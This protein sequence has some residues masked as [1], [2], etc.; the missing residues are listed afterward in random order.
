[1]LLCLSVLI[2]AVM[3]VPVNHASAQA[4]RTIVPYPRDITVETIDPATK[5]PKNMFCIGVNAIDVKLT[6]NSGYRKYVYV[7]NRDTSGMERVLYTGWLESGT[8]YLSQLMNT[9]LEVTGPAG[10][11]MIRVDSSDGGQM[12]P[13]NWVSFQVQNCGGGQ[14][15]PYPPYGQATVWAQVAP[16][17]IPQGGKGTITL[18][19][20]VESRANMTYYFEILNSW[21]QLWKRFPASKRPYERYSVTLPVGKTTKPAIL[22][23]TVKLWLEAGIAAERREVASTRFSFHVIEPGSSP[24][25]Y[26]PGYQAYPGYPTYPGYPAPEWYP[27]Y[28]ADPYSGMTPYEGGMPYM[29][30]PYEAY[31][32]GSG[33]YPMGSQGERPIN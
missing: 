11:E 14:Y 22:T 27:S 21:G 10:M 5:T 7:V 24:D 16:Y 33:G 17:A 29:I 32:Y 12:T 8:S 13:G 9:Q 2:I 31:P 26:A 15:P 4:P 6:N 25:P 30:S 19:T 3:I 18:Q 20:T 23:Y 28:G 1:M